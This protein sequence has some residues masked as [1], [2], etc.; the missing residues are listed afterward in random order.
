[1]SVRLSFDVYSCV[2]VYYRYADCKK[3][4]EVCPV[5]NTI[6]LENDRIKVNY[7]S[8]I[9]CGACV[10]NCPTESFKIQGFDLVEFYTKFIEEDGNLISCKLNV[11][12][13]S[14]LDESYLSAMCIE[15]QNDLVLDIK[16]CYNCSIGKQL[17][18]IKANAEKANYILQSAGVDYRVKLEEIGY[19]REEKQEN[20]RRAFLK[21]FVKQTA[22]LA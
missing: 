8:C 9:N 13:L 6:I 14:A 16:H 4:V 2:R 20:K 17:D 5:E 1:M 7:E 22:S 10:G 18:L 21:M 12:C 3:C 11:P 19:E 15:K